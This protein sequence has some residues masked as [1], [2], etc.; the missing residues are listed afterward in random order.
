MSNTRQELTHDDHLVTERLLLRPPHQDDVEFVLDLYSRHDVVQHIGR[1]EVQTSR[2]HA[3]ERIERY[4]GQ[5]TGSS[6]VWLIE[7]QAD[8]AAA[9]FAL[10]EPIPFSD[11]IESEQ[12][13]IEIGWHLHPDSWGSGIATEAAHALIDRA[14]T[15]GT[16]QLVAVT[17][18]QNVASQ[19]VARR[20]GMTYQGPT[21]RYYNTTCELF[22]LNLTASSICPC[23]EKS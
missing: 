23:P 20:L 6:G 16:D 15:H 12:T 3:A 2:S 18:T 13:H 1:G 8:H 7:K 9:G 22:T 19:A 4:R 21:D 11:H 10:M 14:R 5:F 17:H